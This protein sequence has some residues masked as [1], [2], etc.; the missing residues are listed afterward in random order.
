MS[1]LFTALIYTLVGVL[2]I[3]FARSAYR[4]PND[5]LASWFTGYILPPFRWTPK[6][7]RGFC[8]F[9]VF[10][11]V[12]MITSGLSRAMPFLPRA[13]L[14]LW[15]SASVVITLLLIPRTSLSPRKH[16]SGS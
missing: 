7:L 4:R 14:I 9:W 12:L 2:I 5:Y 11:S 8:I 3:R 6:R 13:P 10:A 15:L 16:G 1:P